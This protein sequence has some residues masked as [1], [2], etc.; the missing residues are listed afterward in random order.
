MKKNSLKSTTALGLFC[1]I[2][3]EI[4]V[5]MQPMAPIA[6]AA[7]ALTF[8][9]QKAQAD[10]TRGEVRRTSRRTSRRTTRRQ[11]YY[12]PPVR[13]VYRGGIPHYYYNGVYYRPYMQGGQTV[14]IEVNL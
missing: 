7:L 1:A 9:P 14:Y 10:L 5:L 4:C 3:M 13:P 2:L 11:M 8:T 12:A 6:V